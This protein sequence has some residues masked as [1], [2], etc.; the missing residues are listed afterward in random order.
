MATKPKRPNAI[1]LAGMPGEAP[2]RTVARCLLD[3]ATTAAG[4]LHHLNRKVSAEGDVNGYIAELQHLARAANEGDLSRPE[5]ALTTQA[6]TLDGLFHSLTGWALNNAKEG[7]NPA[8]F[9]TCMRLAF[10]AQSQCRATVETLA[11]IKNP[12]VV[13]ARQANIA[14]G[15]Q[16]VNNGGE[17]SR[18]REIENAPTK[19]L[20]TEH[21]ER[22]DTR[23][24]SATIGTDQT[25]ETMGTVN[26]PE[27]SRG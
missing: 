8:Y 24:T 14:N 10:K 11:A 21:G 6:Q 20:E 18:V 19:L 22:L 15:P 17:T 12:P 23:A 1:S 26:R 3:P 4:T 13:Y 7:G 27:D 5:A 16:Q 9:E 2:S 25:M